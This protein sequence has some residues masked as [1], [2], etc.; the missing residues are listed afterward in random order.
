M[1]YT[2]QCL[3]TAKYYKTRE[4]NWIWCLVLPLG[5]KALFEGDTAELLWVKE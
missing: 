4:I 2:I 5:R 3:Q 1:A